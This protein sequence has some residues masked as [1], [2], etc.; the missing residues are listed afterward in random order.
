MAMGRNGNSRFERGGWPR[1]ANGKAYPFVCWPGPFREPARRL[2]ESNGLDSVTVIATGH[3]EM[4]EI[5]MTYFGMEKSVEEVTE[6]IAG[7]EA[8]AAQT[9]SNT[10]EWKGQFGEAFEKLKV[11][12]RREDSGLVIVTHGNNSDGAKTAAL[13]AIAEGDLDVISRGLL[14]QAGLKLPNPDAGSS[15]GAVG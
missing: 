3:K 13:G 15:Q 2:M 9:G 4:G 10:P 5:A 11:G 6:I 12:C 7:V 14:V 8:K 1:F